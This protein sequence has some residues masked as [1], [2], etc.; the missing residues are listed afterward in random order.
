MEAWD[1]QE[2]EINIQQVSQ[3]STGMRSYWQALEYNVEYP[4]ELLT[5]EGELEDKHL[6]F[7]HR[8]SFICFK[9]FVLVYVLRG[10]GLHS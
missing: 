3:F 4:S 8:C 1:K 10:Y 6:Y 5:G 2:K 7:Y 9:N